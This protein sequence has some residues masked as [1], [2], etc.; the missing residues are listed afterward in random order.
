MFFF[1]IFVLPETPSRDADSH[2]DVDD[3]L[4]EEN[5][6]EDEKVEGAVTPE[7]RKQMFQKLFLI[8]PT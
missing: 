3:D 7:N 1:Y 5:K 4:S 2:D 8:W 6:K